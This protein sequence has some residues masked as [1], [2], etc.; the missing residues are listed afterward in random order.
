[1]FS[2]KQIGPEMARQQI[3]VGAIFQELDRHRDALLMFGVSFIIQRAGSRDTTY[4]QT[5]QLEFRL[6]I[7][8]LLAM[9]ASDG[10]VVEFVQTFEGFEVKFRLPNSLDLAAI[11]SLEE[12][13]AARVSLIRRCVL[14]ARR[15]DNDV[16]AEEL[17]E[18]VISMMAGVMVE[19]DP[20]SEVQLNLRCPQCQQDWQVTLDIN[21]FF[22][23]EINSHARRLLFEVHSLARVYGW[24]EV[25]ILAM[26]ARRRRLYLEMVS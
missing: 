3:D 9:E 16:P 18:S 6:A 10:A 5:E 20:L 19:Q 12:V 4:H 26:S 11:A 17:P 14:Q 21:S 25:D 7:S 2:Q 8:D 13:E 22:W 24:R 1:M 15:R 23:T